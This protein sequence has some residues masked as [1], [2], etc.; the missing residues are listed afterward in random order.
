[1]SENKYRPEGLLIGTQENREYI[2]SLQGL[3][4]AMSQGRILEGVAVMCDPD[5]NITVDLGAVK[6]LMPKEEI[7]LCSDGEEVKDIVAITRVGKAV[8]FKVIGF[9]VRGG[10]TV[11]ILSRKEAQRE[12]MNSFL[13]DLIPG[14]IIDSKITHL[15]NFGAFVDIGCGIV[16]LLSIDCISVSRISHPR[17]RFSVGA[18]IKTVIKTINYDTGRIY[19]TFKELLGTW[20][21][22]ASRFSIGQTVAGVVRSI[23]SYGI[24]V[25]LAPNLAGLAEYRDDITVG[26]TAAVYIKNII[27]EKMKIKLVLIDSYKGELAVRGSEYFIDIHSTDHIDEWHY[28]PM[29]CAKQIETVFAE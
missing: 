2:L 25:E 10:D 7:A 14:D 28:S 27:P 29:G 18:Y 26:Q 5:H 1:M 15:D 19:V 6:G 9:T 11:A 12:C 8:C 13:M 23:E 17:D 4:R 22:N 21:E 20:E 3:E 16:S 24:F